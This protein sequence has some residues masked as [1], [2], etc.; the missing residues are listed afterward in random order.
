MNESTAYVDDAESSY[1]DHDRLLDGPTPLSS[2]FSI[3]SLSLSLSEV[4]RLLQIR[5]KR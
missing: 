5:P 2:F 4:I 3:F 1:L